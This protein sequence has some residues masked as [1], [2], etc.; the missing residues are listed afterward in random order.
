MLTMPSESTSAPPWAPVSSSESLRKSEPNWHDHQN[1]AHEESINLHT[2]DSTDIM[3]NIVGTGLFNGSLSNNKEDTTV[4]E[5]NDLLSEGGISLKE[6]L[7]MDESYTLGKQQAL[8]ISEKH[9]IQKEEVLPMQMNKEIADHSSKHEGSMK[10]LT[11]NTTPAQLESTQ[12]SMRDEAAGKAV[13]VSICDSEE[14]KKS[15]TGEAMSDA[16][17]YVSRA[18]P[19]IS[20]IEGEETHPSAESN[21]HLLAGRPHTT[22]DSGIEMDEITGAQGL[23]MSG[24]QQWSANSASGLPNQNLNNQTAARN[25]SPTP[26]LA[27]TDKSTE[28]FVRNYSKEM[29]CKDEENARKS[30]CPDLEVPKEVNTSSGTIITDQQHQN[31]P[32][33]E[34]VDIADAINIQDDMSKTLHTATS[35]NSDQECPVRE[36]KCDLEN[37]TDSTE[38][39]PMVQTLSHVDM[40][41]KLSGGL[42]SSTDEECIQSLE[43]LSDDLEQLRITGTWL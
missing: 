15:G 37:D 43:Q 18:Q 2:L 4:P 14:F 38:G 35:V 19:M 10:L 12:V 31:S 39:Q 42:P 13:H 36:D 27:E 9:E 16:S 29:S 6:S 24:F 1:Q 25:T 5:F 17:P 23:A 3:I 26:L 28:D 41:E 20:H 30:S 21:H 7:N 34:P 40:Q 32:V 8:T 22:G 33:R 11:Q